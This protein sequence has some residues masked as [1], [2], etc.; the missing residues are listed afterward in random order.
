M[1]ATP[2]QNSQ[3]SYSGVVSCALILKFNCLNISGVY[4][5]TN[6]TESK[7]LDYSWAWLENKNSLFFFFLRFQHLVL[8]QSRAKLPKIQEEARWDVGDQ[9]SSPWSASGKKPL[10]PT[11][12]NHS[13]PLL[14]FKQKFCFS[15]LKKL[16]SLH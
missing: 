10:P 16:K 12:S 11:S 5:K 9:S 4:C 3:V 7:F 6:T 2:L 1:C 13:H 8:F 15:S 14:S